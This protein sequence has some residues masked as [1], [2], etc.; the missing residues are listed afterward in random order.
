MCTGLIVHLI[1]RDLFGRRC[2]IR[3]KCTIVS[4]WQK[5]NI[6][7]FDYFLFT[8]PFVRM[9]YFFLYEITLF[10]TSHE[11]TRRRTLTLINVQ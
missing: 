7:V 10:R 5:R 3:I 8:E 1:V 11:K 2:T 4:Q 9:S 6:I